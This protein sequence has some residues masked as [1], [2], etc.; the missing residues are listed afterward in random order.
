[1]MRR[2]AVPVVGLLAALALAASA[3]LAPPR[4]LAY[5]GQGATIMS[6]DLQTDEEGDARSTFGAISADGSYVAMQTEASNFFAADDPDPPGECRIGGVFRRGVDD[7]TLEKVADGDTYVSDS[8]NGFACPSSSLVFQGAENPSIS[9]DGEYVVFSTNEQLTPQPTNGA[10]EVY[11]RDMG[12][13]IPSCDL[14]KPTCT[15]NPF[16]LVS[17]NN[18]GT[19]AQFQ[20]PSPPQPGANPGAA[21]WPGTSVSADGQRV[22]FRTTVASNLPGDGATP[23]TPAQ[24]LFVRDLSAGTTTL[25]TQTISGAQPAGGAFGP[26]SLSADGTAVAWTGTNATEQ[27]PFLAGETPNDSEPY[28]LWRQLSGP[29]TSAGTRRVTG[30]ADLDDPGCD[31]ATAFVSTDETATGPCYGPLTLQESQLSGLGLLPPAL[32]AD[33]YTV[34]FVTAA[35]PR[36]N[37]NKPGV[38]DV[39]V[40]S[41]APGVSRKAGTRELTSAGD[42]SDP[43]ASDPVLGVA[44]SP[45]GTQIALTSQRTEWG[46]LPSPVPTGGF[47]GLADDTD[48]ELVNLS[49]DTIER[50]TVGYDGSDTDGNTV[51]A[52]TLSE[53][54]AR[55]AFASNADN[56]FFGD[57]NSV[58]DVFVAQRQPLPQAVA[59]PPPPA[60]QSNAVTQFPDLPASPTI[61]IS[62]HQRLRDGGEK[63]IVHV[64]TAGTLK[65]VAR[66][67]E[68]AAASRAR[69]GKK[70]KPPRLR[71]LATTSVVAKGAA[72]VAVMLVPQAPFTAL[73]RRGQSFSTRVSLIFTE[74]GGAHLTKGIT[75]TFARIGKA[76]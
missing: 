51:G 57:A 61:S 36:P 21:L 14:T 44:I 62:S 11:E 34:A 60:Q 13:A 75:L 2:R 8:G 19:P 30:I 24:Q 41:M 74:R 52:P 54:G 58:A 29:L 50:V 9:A 65:A 40:T 4:A 46:F 18:D 25:V 48:V 49:A 31:H 15:P 68:H 10:G 72:F 1:M 39:W 73:E 45:D 76:K 53:D 22:L 35:G 3:A 16:T 66:A 6:A 67:R 47:R 42:P 7:A 33:G 20:T 17:V 55:I 43:L 70:P 59:P 63:L 28:Y 38:P 23:T 71:T 56:L 37:P 32:S 69:R 26:S 27:T 64:P 5:Y 12:V